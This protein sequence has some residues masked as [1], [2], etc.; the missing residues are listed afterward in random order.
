M[1]R[2][3][4]AAFAHGVTLFFRRTSHFQVESRGKVYRRL[5]SCGGCLGGGRG[6]SLL[7]LHKPCASEAVAEMCCRCAALPCA[8]RLLD[9]AR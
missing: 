3:H 1:E 8:A 5:A 7:P 4:E 6:Q 9:A 2:A